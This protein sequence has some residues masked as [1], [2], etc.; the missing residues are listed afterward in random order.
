MKKLLISM[1]ILILAASLLLGPVGAQNLVVNPGFE[2][3]FQSVSG[4]YLGQGWSRFVVSGNVSYWGMP[5][6]NGT[7]DP[8]KNNYQRV[9]TGYWNWGGTAIGGFCQSIST[10]PGQ[11][12]GFEMDCYQHV[13]GNQ[14]LN[15]PPYSQVG[16]DLTGQTSNP[17]AASIVWTTVDC[18]RFRKQFTATGN[19]VSI[20]RRQVQPRVI[21]GGYEFVVDSDNVLV[22]AE[23]QPDVQITSGPTIPQKGATW[24]KIVWTTD[25][26]S[27]SRVNYGTTAP[28]IDKLPV[29]GSLEAPSFGYSDYVENNILTT[30]HVVIVSGLTPNTTYSFNVYSGGATGRHAI[31]SMQKSFSTLTSDPSPTLMNGGFE[32]FDEQTGIPNYWNM[33]STGVNPWFGLDGQGTKPVPGRYPNNEPNNWYRITAQDGGYFL[34]CDAVYSQAAGGAFQQVQTSPSQIYTASAWVIT[35][36]ASLGYPEQPEGGWGDPSSH[37]ERN[38]L[39]CLAVDPTGG[40]DPMMNPAAGSEETVLG[41][42]NLISTPWT[43]TEAYWYYDQNVNKHVYQQLGW[44][45]ISVQVQGQGGLATVYVLMYNKFPMTQNVECV[46][47]V[48]WVT[49]GPPVST[50]GE[51]KSGALGTP[52]DITDAIVTATFTDDSGSPIGFAV[53]E[54]DRFAGIRVAAGAYVN[55]GDKVSLTGATTLQNGELVINATSVTVNSSG[56]DIPAAVVVNGLETGGGTFGAQGAVVDDATASPAKM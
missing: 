27:T 6:N 21:D 54:P 31:W 22:Q 40:T 5:K 35:G 16:Y 30:D 7:V 25:V 50:V 9:L 20:W 37:P 1:S 18:G 23:S 4:G 24:V 48:T 36:G 32:G 28:D 12:Y 11:L 10:S 43:C 34:G 13:I 29:G 55:P 51:A 2:N 19:T 49:S 15:Q 47:S 46:D 17:N 39:A 52:V 26:P 41:N 38:R 33:Y 44:Q 56:N 53:E 3:G 8:T 42:P 14:D 45:Q